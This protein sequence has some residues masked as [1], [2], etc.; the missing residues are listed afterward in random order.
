MNNASAIKSS[1]IS[2]IS[3]GYKIEAIKSQLEAT[4]EPKTINA[5]MADIIAE[6][7]GVNDPRAKL[8]LETA[9]A[10]ISTP[11]APQ[12]WWEQ[13]KAPTAPAPAPAP[14]TKARKVIDLDVPVLETVEEVVWTRAD[15][16]GSFRVI[17]RLDEK[18]LN[19]LLQEL[20]HG[21]WETLMSSRQYTTRA[22]LINLYA[23][24]SAAF[25]Q[26][27]SPSLFTATLGTKKCEF[28]FVPKSR[29]IVFARSNGAGKYTMGQQLLSQK[30]AEFFRHTMELFLS[31]DKCSSTI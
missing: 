22:A 27:T 17:H 24:A 13:V 14:A 6:L 8:I 18:G 9:K 15:E 31:I 2:L 10:V 1:L 4:G 30:Q 12:A 28:L 20:H 29:K 16:R 5:V 25:A 7:A 26:A 11:Q 23:R 21:K 3:S 19:A